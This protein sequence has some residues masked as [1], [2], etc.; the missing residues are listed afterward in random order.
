MT[1]ITMSST[2]IA[3]TDRPEY[4]IGV[5]CKFS[6][7]GVA[8]RYP[9]NTTICHISPS[10]SLQTG[11]RN[12]Y[13][14]LSS[15]P[16]LGS[17]I[18]LVP[19]ESWHMTVLDGVRE[20]ECQPGMWPD[21]MEKKRLV[22]YTEDFT[23]SLRELGRELSKESLAPPFRMRVR[24]FDAGIVGS[25]LEVEGATAEEEQRMH[26]LRD[27][28]ADAV[29]FRAPN[30]ET[31]QF[32]VTIAYLMRHV[33]GVDRVEFNRTLTEHLASVR[34]EFELGA[35]EFCTFED[36]CAYSRVFYLGTQDD[37]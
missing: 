14:A 29:G 34:I 13:T 11:L 5:P 17:V 32:H 22:E 7:D 26:R 24:G 30:H 18:R 36:M 2:Q 4:P 28:L 23:K 6:P 20:S 12:V 33:D 3:V 19:P 21:G 9:G 27:R 8:Q 1:E 31:Y 16:T 15:H 35:V 25:G 37:H 10:S